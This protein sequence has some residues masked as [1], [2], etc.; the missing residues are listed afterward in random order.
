MR[1]ARGQATVEVVAMLPLLAAAALALLQVLAAGVARELAGHAAEAGAVALAQGKDPRQA[2]RD[3]VPAWSRIDVHVGGRR[4]RV[5]VRPP[6]IVPSLG[7]L[8]TA[9]VAADAGPVRP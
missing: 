8:L 9:D 3:A 2:A 5:Q 1:G 4:V 7:S 6:A